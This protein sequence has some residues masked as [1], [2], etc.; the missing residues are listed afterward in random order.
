MAGAWWKILTLLILL[1]VVVAG[2]FVPL[3]PGVEDVRINGTAKSGK[4]IDLLVGDNRDLLLTGYNTRF[5]DYQESLQ[6]WVANN[7]T[8]TLIP[9][10]NLRVLGQ[11]TVLFDLSMPNQVSSRDLHIFMNS[12]GDGTS[13]LEHAAFA[14]SANFN[15]S[16]T[17]VINGEVNVLNVKANYFGF[18]FRAILYETIRN[19]FFH[20][21]M[22]FAM[23]LILLVG[24]I[25]SVRFLR[26]GKL[27]DDLAAEQAAKVAL[28]FGFLGIATGSVWARYTWGAWWVADIKLNGAAITVLVYLAYMVLRKALP[29]P[30]TRGRIA[31]VYSIFAFC[32]MIVFIQ[33]IPRTVD[34]SLHPGNAG[35]PAFST[36]DLDSSLRAVFYPAV[37]GW[38]LLGYW[39]Y[40]VQTRV[41]ILQEKVLEHEMG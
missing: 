32:L 33:V 29:N 23:M 24:L 18:P 39:I 28:L 22:W 41:S 25:K 10:H 17:P 36:Y 1:Y 7:D 35:N 19:L 31:A 26:S 16:A 21:P 13:W 12:D 3:T 11:Q 9:A 4:T 15:L 2:L 27:E 40:R 5:Q 8:S 6:I 14:D 37:L 34:D 30:E 38:S 20:V